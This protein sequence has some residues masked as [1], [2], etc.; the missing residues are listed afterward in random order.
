MLGGGVACGAGVIY[1]IVC[2]GGGMIGGGVCDGGGVTEWW[3]CA[4]CWGY[5]DC[6]PAPLTSQP[7]V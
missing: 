1:G 3:C 2:G 4:W 7:L 5:E 6:Q